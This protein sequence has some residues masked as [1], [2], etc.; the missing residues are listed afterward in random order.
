MTAVACLR[1]VVGEEL[2]FADHET[3]ADLVAKV[4]SSYLES[5]WLWPRR[6]GLVAP[7]AFVLADPRVTLLDPRELQALAAEL[8]IKLF[9]QESAGDVTLLTLEGDQSDVMRFAGASRAEIQ[10]LLNGEIEGLSSRVCKITRDGVVSLAPV[11]G[12]IVGEPPMEALLAAGPPPDHPAFRGVYHLLREQFIGCALI[13]QATRSHGPRSGEYCRAEGTVAEH[14]VLGIGAAG[15]ALK[16]MRTGR[17]F[18]PISFSTLAKPTGRA[19]LAA[20]LRDLPPEMRPRLAASVYD[21]PRSPAFQALTQARDLLDPYFGSID[22]RVTDPNFQIDN[23]APDQA[24]SVTLMLSDESEKQRIAAIG[25][26][27]AET[28]AYHRKH[29]LQGVAEVR[30]RRELEA[31][32]RF[33]AP[34]VSGPGICE[35]QEEPIAD[36]ICPKTSLPLRHWETPAAAASAA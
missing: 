7:F 25:R 20:A 4:A 35:L 3:M 23:L 18:L 13:W 5:R 15:Q 28:P 11:G 2:L 8:H 34:F 12:S 10:A 27:M 32:I 36:P 33:R 1:F 9:G 17:L 14:D 26:F 22:L 21:T 29:I 19:Q 6:Y 16:S 30:T 31:C 24:K